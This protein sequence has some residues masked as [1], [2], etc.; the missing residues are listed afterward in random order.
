MNIYI[1]KEFEPDYNNLVLAAK[2]QKPK[3]TPI[4]E[5]V[6]SNRIMEEVS[7]VKISHAN[8][9]NSKAD[10]VE[11]YKNFNKAFKVLGYDAACFEICA[12]GYMPGSGSLGGH[13]DGFADEVAGINL[14][15]GGVGNVRVGADLHRDEI[16][17]VRGYVESHDGVGADVE[18]GGGEAGGGARDVDAVAKS[19]AGGGCVEVAGNVK[20][21]AVDFDGVAACSVAHVEI[22]A[23][24]D[25]GFASG[26]FVD[27]EVVVVSAVASA[28]PADF[29]ASGRAE[30]GV[31]D[32]YAGIVAGVVGAAH[33]VY[34]SGEVEFGAVEDKEAFVP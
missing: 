10:T 9:G 13:K 32:D 34:I 5:H 2:N 24:T 7:G 4:Y 28:V 1:K 21:S 29:N 31:A 19:F 22:A 33:E 20:M 25:E 27:E 12:A 26:I 30:S 14:D 15:E 6:V 8:T 17:T 11:Y 18:V 16:V 3:R 23:E